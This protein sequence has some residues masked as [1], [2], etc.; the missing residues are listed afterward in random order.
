VTD[1]N[2]KKTDARQKDVHEKR[3]NN[4]DAELDHRLRGTAFNDDFEDAE[5][6]GSL[7]LNRRDDEISDS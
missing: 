5:R 3:T 2:R 7:G 4:R 6:D 1:L